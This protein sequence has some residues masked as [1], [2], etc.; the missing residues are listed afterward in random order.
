MIVSFSQYSTV[1]IFVPTS[2]DLRDVP[3]Q[4][5]GPQ[6][7]AFAAGQNFLNDGEGGIFVYDPESTASDDGENV[8]N[9]GSI[10]AGRWLRIISNDAG[11]PSAALA[12]T[13]RD[14]ALAAKNAAET[15]AGEA[16]A[17]VALAAAQ[18]VLAEAQVD[19]AA[20]TARLAATVAGV[21]SNTYATTLPKGVTSIAITATGSGFTDGTY[22]G[23]VSGGPSG[24]A[25]TYT[26]SGGTV[27]SAKITNAGLSSATTAPTL[28]F[29]NG[30]GTGA[31]ATATVSS[32]IPNQATYW[33]ASADSEALLLFRNNASAVAP[34]NNPDATQIELPNRA[35]LQSVAQ[36]IAN[37]QQDAFETDISPTQPYIASII[38]R[39]VLFDAK[40]HDYRVSFV[41]TSSTH[42]AIDI[43]DEELGGPVAYG[44]LASPDYE[45]LP[46][47]IPVISRNRLPAL[48][49]DT[50]GWSGIRGYVELNTNAIVESGAAYQPASFAQ[51]GIKRTNVRTSAD[52]AALHPREGFEEVIRVG[53]DRNF[54]TLTAAVESTYD[55]PLADPNGIA[56]IP[57]C[58]RANPLHRILILLDA[59]TYTAHNLH[60]PD[61]V[62]IAGVNRD[63]VIVEH[64]AGSNRP[65]IQGHLNHECRD[66]TLRNT[67]TEPYYGNPGQYAWHFDYA[68]G[69]LTR[70]SEGDVN[71]Q[72][73]LRF[74]NVRFLGGPDNLVQPF[75]SGLPVNCSVEFI[76]CEFDCENPAFAQPF[77]AAHNS[78]DGIGGGKFIFRNCVD[79][80]GRPA[81]RCS[82]AVQ[83]TYDCSFPS[84]LI[85]DNCKGFERVGLSGSYVDNWK[86][87]GSF[88]GSV[89]SSIPGDDMGLS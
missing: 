38:Q 45:D 18:V 8:I 2:I 9:T 74:R 87:I 49:P 57:T 64:A 37:S 19:T 61:Y 88:N 16:Q 71:R 59:G 51:G 28:S 36:A 3:L 12:A 82:V 15:A 63:V 24:F 11:G 34:V 35:A 47:R 50:A 78:S 32:L 75:G 83:T 21:Y 54:T 10:A 89:V 52:V 27:A 13:Y 80:S 73:H 62:S 85:I 7:L 79:K 69:F 53:P 81:P 55:A 68:Q 23:G 60:L 70:D 77:A 84:H 46:D 58:F 4:D 22:A 65:I 20:E 26:V 25:W 86:L 76:D 31:T 6:M 67:T 5:I 40:E 42:I 14:A 56:V 41:Q 66:L 33:A 43:W 72:Y 17:Q 29:P 48:Y 44:Y 1:S 30:A 39:I